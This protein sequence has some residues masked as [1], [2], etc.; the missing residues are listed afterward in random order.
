M[1]KAFVFDNLNPYW[2]VGYLDGGWQEL[3]KRET[4]YAGVGAAAWS[5]FL[6]SWAVEV[7]PA[8]VSL[9]NVRPAVWGVCRQ[10]T[11]V[12]FMLLMF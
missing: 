8:A 7:V 1:F 10:R 5:L 9:L 3:T 4:G 11:G 2:Q 6:S 12:D